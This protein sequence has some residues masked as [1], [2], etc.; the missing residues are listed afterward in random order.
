MSQSKIAHLSFFSAA[1]LATSLVHGSNPKRVDAVSN[2]VVN[3]ATNESHGEIVLAQVD[4][5]RFDAEQTTEVF[6]DDFIADNVNRDDTSLNESKLKLPGLMPLV[7]FLLFFV[8][9]GIFYPLF[10]FY[11]MLLIKPD[12]SKNVDGVNGIL[13]VDNEEPPTLENPPQS[14]LPGA[15]KPDRGTVSKLQIAFSPTASHLREELSKVG[16]NSNLNTEYDLVDLMHQTVAILINQNDW[17][18]ISCDSTTLSLGKIQPQFNLISQQERKKIAARQENISKYKRNITDDENLKRNYNYVVVTL[19]LC[20][21]HKTPL[22]G[23]IDTKKQLLEKL[24][25]LSKMQKHSLMKFEVLWNPQQ[26]NKYL[27]NDELL[28]EYGNLN[29]LL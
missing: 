2:K 19:I 26:L 18:H 6:S 25:E 8:P 14:S 3:N 28:M 22:F 7:L 10:L 23:R 27:S 13:A 29:R 11:K 5:P 9:L 21:S 20:T 15:K 1:L 17:T 24:V 16:F 4:L 12:E